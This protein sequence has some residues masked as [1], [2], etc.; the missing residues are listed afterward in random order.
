MFRAKIWRNGT[1]VCMQVTQMHEAWRGIGEIANIV[2]DRGLF[3]LRSERVP[4]LRCDVVFIPGYDTHRDDKVAY[5]H[6]LSRVEA[7]IYYAKL[8]NI[9]LYAKGTIHE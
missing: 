6:L 8:K 7:Q 9:L 4:E 1:D 2:D 3:C 5:F